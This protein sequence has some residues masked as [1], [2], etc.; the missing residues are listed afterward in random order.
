MVLDDVRRSRGRVLLWVVV[1]LENG[2]SC[3][4]RD[5]V[6]TGGRDGAESNDGEVTKDE[7]EPGYSRVQ[8]CV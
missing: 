6:C 5:D 3:C 7:P 4:V 8:V 1:L 2:R